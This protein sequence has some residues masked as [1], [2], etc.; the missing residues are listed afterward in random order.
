[1][2]INATKIGASRYLSRYLLAFT[3]ST[4]L[5]TINATAANAQS[6]EKIIPMGEWAEFI[7]VNFNGKPLTVHL[8][9]GYERA[10]KFPEA[11]EI[12]SINNVSN[13]QGVPHELPNTK[14]EV[15][16]DVIGFAPLQRF[17]QQTINVRGVESGRTYI[18]KVRSSP[19]GKRQPI[20]IIN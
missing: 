10:I 2:K 19:T 5:L 7:T 8:R 17:N 13:H 11:V 18:L 9:T 1:M 20:Q 14:I 16:A 15:D 4:L 6:F 3:L 12:L